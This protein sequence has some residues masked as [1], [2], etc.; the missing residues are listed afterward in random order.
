MAKTKPQLVQSIFEARYERGYRYL[1]RCGDTMVILEEALP[2]ISTNSIWMPEDMR[3]QGARMK[4]PD[5]N[6]TLVFDAY[7]LCLDQNPADVDCPFADISKYSFDTVI[8]KFDIR[9]TT[10]LG[11]RRRYILPT[12]SIEAAEALSVKRAPLHD[13]LPVTSD[14]MMPKSCDITSV[15][16]N[17]ERSKGLRFSISP[18]FKVEAPL[19]LDLR[20]SMSP[21]L[22]KEGQREALIGQLKRQK[23]REKD[24]LA[25]LSIDIDHWWANPEKT[26]IGEF[27]DVSRMQIENALDSFLERHV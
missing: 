26:D 22:L 6:L 3:P 2:K 25:G 21:H 4:C 17:K 7:R 13:W 24:P 23:Q 20:L 11:N 27:L 18:T 14:E 5:M 12:D 10:R 1:D 15:L 9:E 8:S 19:T 16:E